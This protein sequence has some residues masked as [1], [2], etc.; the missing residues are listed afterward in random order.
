MLDGVVLKG[1]S[2]FY[3][4]QTP[5][6]IWECSL[7]GRF[8]IKDQSF[9]PG[10]RVRIQPVGGDKATIEEVLPR[11]NELIRPPVAN[12]DQVIFILAVT[13]PEP[14][15]ALLDRL[16][17]LAESLGVNPLICWNKADL[18]A[19]EAA[20]EL[21]R[22]YGTIGYQALATSAVDGRGLS[23]ITVLLRGKVSV[24]AGPSGVGKSSLLNAIHP[25]FGRKTAEVSAK[26]RRGRHT[27]RHVELLPLESG[28]LV[29]DTPGF[30]SLY[31]P[32]MKREE[33]DEYF[34]EIIDVAA[35][36]R[37]KSCLHHHEPNCAVKEALT[38]GRVDQRRYSSY[39]ELLAEVIANERSY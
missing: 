16:L 4:V 17:V 38:A 12:V 25:S 21:C 20:E 35:A 13:S 3:Y 8:R 1:Y 27:T 23:E 34:P 18:L 19:P 37:F 39:L 26:N 15:L 10:D 33:L 5:E 29:A 31:L 36:C 9:L 24:F 6:K 11:K 2:G 7:R 30:S 14:N 22:L 32:K 28:G